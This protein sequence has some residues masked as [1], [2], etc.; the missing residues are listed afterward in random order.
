MSLEYV[1][2]FLNNWWN[3]RLFNLFCSI[4]SYPHQFHFL[5]F[6]AKISPNRREN[7]SLNDS[8]N[9]ICAIEWIEVA[10]N[11]G[12]DVTECTRRWNGMVGMFS[13]KVTVTH[14]LL[15]PTGYAMFQLPWLQRQEEGSSS[16][17]CQ[18][19]IMFTIVQVTCIHF[20]IHILY[21][22][23]WA[24]RLSKLPPGHPVCVLKP[25]SGALN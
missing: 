24:F 13:I 21:N 14:Y 19:I 4:S 25:L 1:K 9:E 5:V 23:K 18:S 7:D 12:P 22:N 17:Q 16:L 11:I 20:V 8:L 2:C 10:S 6:W 3:I 15:T